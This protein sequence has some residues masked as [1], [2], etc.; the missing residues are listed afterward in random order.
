MLPLNPYV[1]KVTRNVLFGVISTLKGATI[2][3]DENI[4]IK[5]ATYKTE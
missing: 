3:G 2:E 4:F 5:I 1:Q